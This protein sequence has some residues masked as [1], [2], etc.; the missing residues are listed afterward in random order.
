[1]GPAPYDAGSDLLSEFEPLIEQLMI[2]RV[3]GSL[4]SNAQKRTGSLK[5]I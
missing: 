5:V 2:I 1:M 3:D 4:K